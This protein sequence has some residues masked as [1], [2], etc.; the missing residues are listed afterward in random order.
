M[1]KE[2]FDRLIRVA[3]VALSIYTVYLLMKGK[4]GAGGC[5][6]KDERKPLPTPSCKGAS[7]SVTPMSQ[8]MSF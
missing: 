4:K 2:E 5:G 6:C 8:K 7:G 1:N 3:M